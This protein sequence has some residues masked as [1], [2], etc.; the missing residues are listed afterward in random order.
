MVSIVRCLLSLV[1]YGLSRTSGVSRVF[2]DELGRWSH[3]PPQ[4]VTVKLRKLLL[5]PTGERILRILRSHEPPERRCR[6]YRLHVSQDHVPTGH[7][8]E[9]NPHAADAQ[10][11]P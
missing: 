10:V 3:A 1:L 11:P 9:V 7:P 8:D 5:E 2:E 4:V 6:V